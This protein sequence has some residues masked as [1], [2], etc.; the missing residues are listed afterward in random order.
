MK[1]LFVSGTDTGVGKSVV[2]GLLARYANEQGLSVITQKWIQTGSRG[3][4]SDIK[5]HLKIMRRPISKIG[6]YRDAVSPYNFPLPI[7]PHKAS[8]LEG[9]A[10][11]PDKIK[12]SFCKL[13]KV[14]DL[15]IVEGVGG[16]L[17]PYNKNDL[18][19]DIVRDLN[20][21]VLLVAQ[22]KLGAINHTLLTIEALATRKLRCLGIVFNNAKREK[23][24]ILED[25][26]RIIKRLSGKKVFGV[27]PWENNLRRLYN[28][29]IPIGKLILRQT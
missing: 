21:S 5:L 20:L 29:F 11:Q 23:K 9:K 4:S 7:S 6:Q 18:V 10:I 28:E 8:S 24:I 26:P 13:A 17:V 22:N 27:L 15:V 16:L 2:C 25:N 12:A 19:I 14:F 3:F 1:A